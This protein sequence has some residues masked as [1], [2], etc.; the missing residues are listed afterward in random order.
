[1]KKYLYIFNWFFSR[2]WFEQFQAAPTPLRYDRTIL[3]ETDSL[4][5]LG[6]AVKAWLKIYA[7]E[8]CLAGDCQTSWPGW[9]RATL[10]PPPPITGFLPKTISSLKVQSNFTTALGGHR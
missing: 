10:P 7:D 3:P 6:S 9:R 1:M 8:I 2:L 4:Y 5:S